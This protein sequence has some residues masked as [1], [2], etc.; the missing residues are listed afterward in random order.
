MSQ[1]KGQ[2]APVHEQRTAAVRA[3][4]RGDHDWVATKLCLNNCARSRHQ[5][6]S[7]GEW[8]GGYHNTLAGPGPGQ[9]TRST[10][11]ESPDSGEQMGRSRPGGRLPP[12]PNELQWHLPPGRNRT[13]LKGV[14][15]YFFSS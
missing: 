11:D 13:P 4:G 5:V 15:S 7:S 12:V 1:R 14:T 8:L 2:G 9:L 6:N 10:R 3:L